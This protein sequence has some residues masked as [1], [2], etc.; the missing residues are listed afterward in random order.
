M[1]RDELYTETG[2]NMAVQ[3]AFDAGEEVAD[4][5]ARAIANAWHGGQGSPFYSFAS[6]GNYDRAA[7]LAELS[8]VI[9]L[10][11]H[12]ANN[13]DRL[14]LDMLGTYLVNRDA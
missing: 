9:A 1:I 4:D 2:L 12:H 7:L 14:S 5:V 6:S 10:S 13:R 3:A 11:Y 8:S